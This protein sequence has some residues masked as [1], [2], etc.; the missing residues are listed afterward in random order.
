MTSSLKEENESKEIW[1][2]WYEIKLG[3]WSWRVDDVEP[4]VFRLYSKCDGK[5]LDGSNE[6][7]NLVCF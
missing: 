2:K 6:W 5:M 4:W 7:Y 1:G 3:K